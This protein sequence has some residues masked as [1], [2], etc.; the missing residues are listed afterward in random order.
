MTECLSL[1]KDSMN[2]FV[3]VI[4]ILEKKSTPTMASRQNRLELLRQSSSDTEEIYPLWTNHPELA[5]KSTTRARQQGRQECLLQGDALIYPFQVRPRYKAEIGELWRA[6]AQI[7]FSSR[8]LSLLPALSDLSVLF[9]VLL[10]FGSTS[11]VVF[12][13]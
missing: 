11:L 10:G 5:L 8:W 1:Q 13:L 9:C 3:Y 2:G 6:R 7:C 4:P 12:S